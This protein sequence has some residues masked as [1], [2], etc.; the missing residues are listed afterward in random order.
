MAIADIAVTG[1]NNSHLRPPEQWHQRFRR[2]RTSPPEDRSAL[3]V[4]DVDRDGGLDLITGSASTGGPIC[5]IL[6]NDGHGKFNR[7]LDYFLG[8][9]HI[10]DIQVGD[11]DGDGD[12]DIVAAGYQ[13]DSV[14][15]LLITPSV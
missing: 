2:S 8:S 3:A 4:A 10:S 5:S 1:I 7:R 12:L 6:L 13:D 15:V 14:C 9:R 11:V